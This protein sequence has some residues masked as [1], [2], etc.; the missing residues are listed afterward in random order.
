MDEFRSALGQYLVGS[1]DIADLEAAIDEA[2]SSQ[3]DAAPQLIEMLDELYKGGRLPHQILA[4]LKRRIARN[5]QAAPDADESPADATRLAMPSEPP[6]APDDDE[7]TRFRPVSAP[8]SDNSGHPDQTTGA[9]QTT[10]VGQTTGAGQTTGVGQT[11][12]AGQ[13]TGQGQLDPT[14][15]PLGQQ[16]AT[17]SPGFTGQTGGMPSTGNWSHPSEWTGG[18]EPASQT[19]GTGTVLKGQYVLEEKIGQGGMGTVFKARDLIKEEAQDRNPYVAIKIL[20]ED[21]KR[22]PRA[23]QALQREASKAQNLAHPNIVF[24]GYF[25]R[26]GDNVFMQM[27]LLEG[28]PLDELNKRHS[29]RGLPVADAL[30]LVQGLAAGLSHAHKLGWCTRISNRPMRS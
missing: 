14:G 11:T 4:V 21:F 25:G 12:G 2:L 27:E 15:Q 1:S 24:V 5:Q 16:P 28:E 19:I 7:A 8:P 20:N 13:T 10:G 6:A 23:L 30:P 18:G 9:A 22:H 3:S 26:D 29:M 17:T